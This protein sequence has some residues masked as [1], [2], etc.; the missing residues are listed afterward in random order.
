MQLQDTTLPVTLV[1]DAPLLPAVVTDQ[2]PLN[3][4]DAI[5]SA[6]AEANGEVVSRNTLRLVLEAVRDGSAVVTLYC[7]GT[8]VSARCLWPSSIALTKEK[9]IVADCYCT[10]RREHRRFRL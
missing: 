4:Y 8:E 2:I 1:P 9:H 10:L 7:H 3:L 5:E 6:F